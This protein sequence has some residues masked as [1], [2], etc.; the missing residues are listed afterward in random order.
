MTSDT[1]AVP[2]LKGRFPFRLGTTSYIVPDEIL[3][4]LQYLCD[5]V[6]DV[7]LVLFESDQIS[8]LPTAA[9]VAQFAAIGR[10]HRLS[11]T[12][13][14]PTDTFLGASDEAV[15]QASVGKC[16]RVI[17]RLEPVAPFAY[18]LHF[19][20]DRP[21]GRHAGPATATPAH[22]VNAWQTAL[23]RSVE[24]LLAAGVPAAML[25]VENLDYP[26]EF[27]APILFRY[28]LGITLDVG[29]ILFYGYPLD[30]YLTAYLPKTRVIHL[31]GIHDGKD[32]RALTG[33][34]PTVLRAFLARLEQSDQS[35]VLTM[36]IFGQPDFLASMNLL[37][38]LVS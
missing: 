12:I 20:S 32:H 9:D 14:L 15:R 22:D 11:Y 36:E 6:D 23:S 31:H 34:D 3:P 17:R 10:Q 2:G 30:D 19:Q 18:V 24:D 28:G 7:E 5:K 4:N 27:A 35:R 1:D 38:T 29:H 26:F 25:C 37:E 16:L 33:I 21:D 8:N 13:H